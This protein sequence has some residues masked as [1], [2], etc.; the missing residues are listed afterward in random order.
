[1]RIVTLILAAFLITSC[2]GFNLDDLF[3]KKENK[4]ILLDAQ[5]STDDG[6]N[7]IALTE[8]STIIFTDEY[9]IIRTAEGEIK[10]PLSEINNISYK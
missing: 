10:Y 1:M 6:R 9:M 5:I 2:A 7:D 8:G 4:Q 3:N